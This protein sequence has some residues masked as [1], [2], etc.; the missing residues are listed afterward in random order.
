MDV[1]AKRL[2]PW[3]LGSFRSARDWATRAE[4]RSRKRFDTFPC[5][6]LEALFVRDG[7]GLGRGLVVELRELEQ[8]L[9]SVGFN[10]FL[11][12]HL[13]EPFHGV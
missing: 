13:S 9:R 3:Q 11:E 8:L 7:I 1:L 4:S 10:I 5:Q 12:R 2:T 6:P